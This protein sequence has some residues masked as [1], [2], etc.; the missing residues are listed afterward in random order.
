MSVII[1]CLFKNNAVY[2]S[3]FIIFPLILLLRVIA[4]VLTSAISGIASPQ[5]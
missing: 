4:T 1:T 3:T 5:F 2:R